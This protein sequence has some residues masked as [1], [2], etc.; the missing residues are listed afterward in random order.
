MKY[1]ICKNCGTSRDKICECGHKF[2]EVVWEKY[3]EIKKK[4]GLLTGNI[5]KPK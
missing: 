2:T 4:F 1:Y 5:K 3:R